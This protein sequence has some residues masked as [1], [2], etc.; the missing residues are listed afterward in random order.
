MSGQYGQTYSLYVNHKGR[1]SHIQIWVSRTVGVWVEG[2]EDGGWERGYHGLQH[3]SLSTSTPRSA[4][5]T[6]GGGGKEE[7]KRREGELKEEGEDTYVLQF[8]AIKWC[9]FAVI[10]ENLSIFAVITKNV[11]AITPLGD[12]DMR[13]VFVAG[14]FEMYVELHVH[15]S[16]KASIT[17]VHLETLEPDSFAQGPE[18]W[19]Y[20]SWPAVMHSCQMGFHEYIYVL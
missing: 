11:A 1:P 15:F 12:F 7:G 16:W 17:T 13:P 10:R 2:I 20:Y 4:I 6:R 5:H 8:A 19:S 14:H 9:K 3:S 18:R